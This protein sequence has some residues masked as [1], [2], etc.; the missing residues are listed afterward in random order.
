MLILVVQIGAAAAAREAA[1][2]A[3]AAAATRA[4]RP[5][6]DLA[7]ETRRLASAITAAVPG[8]TGLTVRVER[9]GRDAVAGAGFRWFPPGPDWI[10]LVVRVESRVPVVVP[11]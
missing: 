4:A 1:A 6:A 3:A 8:A 7:A 10:P 2:A 11:P 5:D 9:R